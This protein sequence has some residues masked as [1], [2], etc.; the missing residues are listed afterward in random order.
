MHDLTH[1]SGLLAIIH[2]EAC[3]ST[4]KSGKK[5]GKKFRVGIFLEFVSLSTRTVHRT[6]VWAPGTCRWADEIELTPA[7]GG[8]EHA[9]A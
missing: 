5:S 9:N 3:L 6:P 4:E 7:R 1:M 2:I 8:I